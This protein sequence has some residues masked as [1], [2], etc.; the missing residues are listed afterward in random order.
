MIAIETKYLGPTN[1]RPS[2]IKAYTC[3]GQK[4]TISY[5]EA[6]AA[7]GTPAQAHKVVAEALRDKAGW[8]G[9]LIGGGT[10]K[11]YVWVFK[12]SDY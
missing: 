6:D 4:L 12:D 7:N 1:Y 5:S 2:R 8:E 9:D 10:S 11:G 3:N